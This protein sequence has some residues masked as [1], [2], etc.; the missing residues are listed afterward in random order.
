MKGLTK[1]DRKVLFRAAKIMEEKLL[2]YYE[3]TAENPQDVKRYCALKLGSA[4]REHFMALYFNAKNNLIKSEILFSGTVHSASVHA[5]EVVKLGLSCNAS[6]VIFC[7]NHPSG[8][9][10]P[11]QADQAIT[12]RIKEALEIVDIRTLD[13]IIVGGNKTY[14]FAEAG[15]I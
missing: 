13:H 14:S 8:T 4:E 2:P 6:A 3:F 12:E 15:L 5:R 1:S 11:S 10:E 7:H 9:A